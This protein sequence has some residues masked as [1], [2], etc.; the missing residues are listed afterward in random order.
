MIHT[1]TKFHCL[2]CDSQV[3]SA[4]CVKLHKT[5]RQTHV[6]C[7]DCG[8]GYIKP[9]IDR[10]TELLRKNFRDNLDHII[11]PGS[12]HSQTRNNCNYKIS[13]R[14]L[15]RLN[16][17]LFLPDHIVIDIHRIFYASL[18]HY[19]ICCPNEKCGNLIQLSPDNWTAKVYCSDCN[20]GW[21]KYCQITPFHVDMNCIE[22]AYTQNSCETIQTIMTLKDTGE[23]K[24][25]RVC[26]APITRV[27]DKNGENEGCNKVICS[28]CQTKS[29]WLCQEINIDYDHFN[30]KTGNCPDK[31]WQK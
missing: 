1:I 20:I 15:L 4:T 17:T 16:D 11:C 7:Q 28:I 2:V 25:C 14:E 24:F 12:Y 23:L 3:S 29:C 18:D 26:N 13:L 22:Y 6:L 10:Y 8:I 21:C 5:R 30:S 19:K 27:K 9:I 31:L